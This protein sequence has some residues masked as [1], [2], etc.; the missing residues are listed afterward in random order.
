MHCPYKTVF[1]FFLNFRA[2]WFF[3]KRCQNIARTNIKMPRY[4]Y[5]LL[6]VTLTAFL[7]F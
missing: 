6:F 1:H 2:R 7:S 5:L 4:N 3:H